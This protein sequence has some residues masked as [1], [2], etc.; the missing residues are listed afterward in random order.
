MQDDC[1]VDFDVAAIFVARVNKPNKRRHLEDLKSTRR[2]MKQQDINADKTFLFMNIDLF[3]LS[4]CSY[5]CHHA[6]R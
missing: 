6:S 5:T 4:D 1:M 2:N 3:Q